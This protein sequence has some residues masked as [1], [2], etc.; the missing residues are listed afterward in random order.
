M[1]ITDGKPLPPISPKTAERLWAGVDQ[2][3][4]PDACWPWKL[5]VN[6]KGYGQ[7]GVDPGRH[8]VLAHRLAYF[9]WYGVDPGSGCVLHKCD[10]PSCCN[11]IHYFLGS[12]RDNALDASSKRRMNHGE[13]NGYSRLEEANIIEIRALYATGLFSQTAIA[14]RFKI[15]QTTVS[16]IVR[17]DTWKHIAP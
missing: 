12:K 9:L 3:G 17:R 1:A 6:N 4:G 15:G 16:H 5:S 11:P 13:R 10:N 8:K 2:S 7:F 14:T